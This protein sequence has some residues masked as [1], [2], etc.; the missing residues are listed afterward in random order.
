VLTKGQN[1]QDEVRELLFVLNDK[2]VAINHASDLERNINDETATSFISRLGRSRP[3]ETNKKEVITHLSYFSSFDL[4]VLNIFQENS[5]HFHLLLAFGI[6]LK[7]TAGRLQG[8]PR[9][10]TVVWQVVDKLQ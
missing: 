1:P 10:A 2:H 5:L 8:I 7:P 6:Y 3:F 9:R 4:F